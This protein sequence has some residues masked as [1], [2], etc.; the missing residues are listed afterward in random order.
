MYRPLRSAS[1]LESDVASKGLAM[2]RLAQLSIRRPKAALAVWAAFAA[3]F[4]A[5]GLGITDRLSPTMTFVPGTESTRAEDL[6]EAEF[7]P[8]TLVGRSGSSTARVRSW[9]RS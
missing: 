2:I 9:S 7:G 4:V 3:I 1:L 6:A 5:I 8:S